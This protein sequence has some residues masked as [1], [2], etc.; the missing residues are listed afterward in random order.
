MFWDLGVLVV[1]VFLDCG[2]VKND[3]I[4][5]E[6]VLEGCGMNV[7]CGVF[8]IGFGGFMWC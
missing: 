2:S 5:G 7:L 8:V 1:V 3:E 6:K 4:V